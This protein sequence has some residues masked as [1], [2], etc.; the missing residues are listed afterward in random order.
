[1]R[2]LLFDSRNEWTDRIIADCVSE[3]SG[4]PACLTDGTAFEVTVAAENQ[5]PPF[6]FWHTRAD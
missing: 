5:E 6:L 4:V 1:M 2:P 3:G